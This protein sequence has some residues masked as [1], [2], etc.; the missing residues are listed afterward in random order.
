MPS[1]LVLT[2]EVSSALGDEEGEYTLKIVE[3]LPDEEEKE[4]EGSDDS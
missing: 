3:V 2:V 4:G 1:D